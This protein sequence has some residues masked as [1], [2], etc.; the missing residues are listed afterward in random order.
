[1]ENRWRRR[2]WLWVDDKLKQRTADTS[3]LFLK[4]DRPKHA[5]FKRKLQHKIQIFIFI[6]TSAKMKR[7]D[8]AQD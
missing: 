2:D 3:L 1:M 8:W 4:P 7:T 6:Q 5:D